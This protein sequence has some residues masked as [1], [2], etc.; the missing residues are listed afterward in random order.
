MRLADV[1]FLYP[2]VVL[3][4][5]TATKFQHKRA[6]TIQSIQVLDSAFPRGEKAP[7]DILD[8][9]VPQ[10]VWSHLVQYSNIQMKKHL[11]SSSTTRY[12]QPTSERELQQFFGCYLSLQ[13]INDTPSVERAFKQHPYNGYSY[14]MDY[15]R[16][17][18]IMSSLSCS[19]FSFPAAVREAW[20][21][22]IVPRAVAACDET[23]YSFSPKTQDSSPDRFYPNKPH[24]HGLLVFHLGIKTPYGP[25][26]HQSI[27]PTNY[28]F[29]SSC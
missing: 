7:I 4:R 2:R 22:L 29:T 19:W 24:P 6:H 16:Y 20:G 21:S 10:T 27:K 3:F 9:V 28:G 17:H 18:A 12:Y 5:P 1:C 23:L 26:M 13:L 14:P 8:R 25:N 11:A 15:H